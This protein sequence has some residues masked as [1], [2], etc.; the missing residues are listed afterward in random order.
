MKHI[1]TVEEGILDGGFG[2]AVAEAIGE[3]VIRIGI[4]SE[5]V[6]CGKRERLLEKYGLTAEAIERRIREALAMDAPRSAPAP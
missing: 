3:P 6:P 5:F 1:I 2:S 4:P